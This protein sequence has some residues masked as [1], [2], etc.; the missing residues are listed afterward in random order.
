[1]GDTGENKVL[2]AY[3]LNSETSEVEV[4]RARFVALATGGAS[5]SYLY[6]TNP[7]I[8]TGDGIAMAWRA[9]C[10]VANMEI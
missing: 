10:R 3:V 6:T 7:D 9:G 2:G 4:F 1:M 8:A 5:K